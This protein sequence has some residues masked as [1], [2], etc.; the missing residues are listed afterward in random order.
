MS[1]DCLGLVCSSPD[2][3]CD[4]RPHHADQTFPGGGA[5]GE[6]RVGRADSEPRSGGKQ[7]DLESMVNLSG[8]DLSVPQRQTLFR[9][10]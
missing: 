9:V 6:L 10:L 5:G 3:E 7:T 2:T 1:L 4:D 8:A